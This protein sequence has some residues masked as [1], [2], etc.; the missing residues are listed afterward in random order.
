VKASKIV[1]P[2]LPVGDDDSERLVCV[3]KWS[4]PTGIW[5]PVVEAVRRHFGATPIYQ[6]GI[7]ISYYV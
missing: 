6:L 5:A 2:H 4:I 1:T 7:A 3:S